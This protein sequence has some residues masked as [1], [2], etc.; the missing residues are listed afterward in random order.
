MLLQKFNFSVDDPSY[1]PKNKQ[2]LTVKPKG[3]YMRAHLRDYTSTK[4]LKQALTSA[5]IHNPPSVQGLAA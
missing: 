3:F 2:T 5:T 4:T 1:Q